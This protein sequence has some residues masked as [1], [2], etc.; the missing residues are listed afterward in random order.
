[1]TLIVVVLND[2][3]DD[4]DL[5]NGRRFLPTASQSSMLADLGDIA[6]DDSFQR[7]VGQYTLRLH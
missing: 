7:E 1:M 6:L 2:S 5:V 3:G 4:L